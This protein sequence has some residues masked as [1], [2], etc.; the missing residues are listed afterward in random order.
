MWLGHRWG[1]DRAHVVDGPCN[2]AL[3]HLVTPVEGGGYKQ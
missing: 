3:R 2:A 1:S